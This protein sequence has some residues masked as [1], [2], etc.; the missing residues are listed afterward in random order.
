M[1]INS[2]GLAG[3]RRSGTN[4]AQ[5]I[6]EMN[7]PVS[8]NAEAKHCLAANFRGTYPVIYVYRFPFDVFSSLYDWGTRHWF[9]TRKPTFANFLRSGPIVGDGARSEEGA[10]TYWSR[11]VRDWLVASAQDRVLAVRY[12][13]LLL[14]ASDTLNQLREF[15][16]FTP[17]RGPAKLPSEAVGPVGLRKP[18]CEV[19][20]SL[21]EF[22][23]AD[24][25][26]VQDI[27]GDLIE[28]Q[29]ADLALQRDNHSKT[30]VATGQ[31][32]R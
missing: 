6:L 7:L 29:W 3:H 20:G 1:S 5:A 11:H 12:E 22:T 32:T 27:V 2:I 13:D 21:A 24:L 15:L 10:V 26:Y 16:R 4:F 31:L 19:G 9:A 18:R 8:V 30:L 23:H 28:A 17:S 14:Q 25:R